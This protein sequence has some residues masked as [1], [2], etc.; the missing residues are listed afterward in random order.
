MSG[1]SDWAREWKI[2]PSEYRDVRPHHVVALYT[3]W[4]GFTSTSLYQSLRDAWIAWLSYR[5]DGCLRL[6]YAGLVPDSLIRW[7]IRQQLRARLLEL[8]AVHVET[9]QSQKMALV[10]QLTNMPV[11]IETSAA[12][13]QHYEVPARFYDLCLGPRKKYSSGY[14][15][16]P[17]STTL[18]ESEVAMLALYCTRANV[19]DGMKNVDG[20][21]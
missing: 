7:G 5:M 8:Q 12:N 6:V 2:L 9:E 18:E 17:Q 15:P 11:A 20:V 1:L 16:H 19:R 10:H 3:L 13:A 4:Q 14:W 21:V